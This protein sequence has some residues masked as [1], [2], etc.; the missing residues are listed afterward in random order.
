M[1]FSVNLAWFLGTEFELSVPPGTLDGSEQGKQCLRTPKRVSSGGPKVAGP[2]L[3]RSRSDPVPYP[4]WRSE[5][6]GCQW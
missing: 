4:C 6:M 1:A 5:R 3:A 2:L